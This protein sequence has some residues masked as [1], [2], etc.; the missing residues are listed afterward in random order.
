[1][2]AVGHQ[3]TDCPAVF[4]RENDSGVLV[5]EK[6]ICFAYIGLVVK[7]KKYDIMSVNRKRILALVLER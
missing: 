1:M 7:T 4:F 2:K 3:K 5:F 6:S